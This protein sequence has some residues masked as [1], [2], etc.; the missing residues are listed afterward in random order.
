MLPGTRPGVVSHVTRTL[1]L[2]DVGV[3]KEGV[4]PISKMASGISNEAG[5]MM[6]WWPRSL[7]RW[8]NMEKW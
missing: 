4:L 7:K 1:A 2:V 8:M 3:E 6:K 5:S